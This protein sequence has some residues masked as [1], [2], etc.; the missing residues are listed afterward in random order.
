M[1]K[2]YDWPKVIESASNKYEPH[3][4]PFYLYDLAT[5]FHSYWSK[6]N[7]DEMYKF[8]KDGKIK[9]LNT[10]LVIKALSIVIENGM[11]ILNVSLPKKM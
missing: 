10:L 11:K 3:R 6:G 5:L 2:I 8:I 9:S 1:R 4:I 7:D